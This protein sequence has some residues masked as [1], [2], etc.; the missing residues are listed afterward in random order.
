MLKMHKVVG[1]LAWSLPLLLA[2]LVVPLHAQDL[3]WPQEISGDKGTLLIYQP[4]PEALD[5]DKLRARAAISIELAGSDEAIFGAMWFESR[6]ATDRD[7]GIVNVVDI[8]V[9]KVGWPDSGDAQEQQL[10]QIVQRAFPEHGLDISMERL[11]ASLETANVERRSLE[12]LKNDPPIIRFTDSLAVLLQFD[13]EPRFEPVPDTGYERALN[14]PFL[15]ARDKARILWLSD[16]QHWYRAGDALGPWELS[17]APPDDLD[18]MV[19]EAASQSGNATEPGSVNSPAP[20]IFVSTEPTEL[21][22]TDGKPNWQSLDG[23]ELLYVKNTE[24]PWLRYLDTGNM[25]LLLSGRWFRAKSAEGPWTFVP[26]T[27]LPGAF[28]KIPP[29]SEIGG[30]RSSVAGTEE[31]EQAMLDAAI[32]QT[33]AVKRKEASLTV[34]YDGKPEFEPIKGTAVSYAVNTSAQVLAIN[35]RYYAVDNGVWFVATNAAGPWAVADE[36]PSDEIAKIP[37]SSP[38]YNVTHVHVYDSTPEI[39]YVGYTPGYVGSYPYY[40]V[41]VYGTGW[42]YPPYWG[43]FYY[44]RPPTWGMHVGYNPWTGWNFGVSWSNGFFSMGV[45]WGGAWG[46]CGGGWYGGGYR[47]PVVINTGDI[48]IGNNV[49]IGNNI[50]VGDRSKISGKLSDGRQS[51]GDRRGRSNVYDRPENRQRLA[52][53]GTR[54]ALKRARPATGTPN[55][56]FADANGNVARRVGDNWETPQKGGW[57]SNASSRRDSIST[58]QAKPERPASADFSRPGNLAGSSFN[59]NEFDRA[60][61]ARN[62]GASREMRRP[63]RRGRRR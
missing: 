47:R 6:I 36:V 25:Y 40:G 54:D 42:Y 16:G 30:L 15:V 17:T 3:Q 48:N 45:S 34:D 27:E 21:I 46:C 31:A 35:G 33:A 57:A 55:N 37:P 52:D 62:T 20:A 8:K 19:Q 32:P 63:A 44:P 43:S 39:V 53:T 11:S 13:G 18:K 5:G 50:S 61:R 49:N 56:V 2:L 24:T 41:P 14:T 60:H 4:Q 9:T 51:L 23:G 7:A 26:A 28:A 59:R 12:S 10:V 58:S 38:V 29:A 1:R 22:V